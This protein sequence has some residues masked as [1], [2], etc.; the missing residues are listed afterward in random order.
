MLVL[1]PALLSEVYPNTRTSDLVSA[2]KFRLA[3]LSRTETLRYCAHLNLFVTD[4]ENPQIHLTQQ[5]QLVNMFLTEGAVK[6]VEGLA[7]TLSRQRYG[8]WLRI[9]IF[10]RGQ[11]LELIRWVSKFCPDQA[12][13]K[14]PAQ[15]NRSKKV[16][17]EAA[18]LATE[19]MIK[20]VYGHVTVDE[21]A[22]T[23]RNSMLGPVR[24][25]AL[26]TSPATDPLRA[27]GRGYRM[28]SEFLPQ[29]CHEFEQVFQEDAK[30][31]LE[32][33]YVC[34]FLFWVHYQNVDLTQAVQRH[35][36]N[37]PYLHEQIPHMAES[38][39]RYLALTAQLPDDLAVNLWI[40]E[41]IDVY[42]LNPLR[43][44]P[45][46]KLSTDTF[47]VL[48]SV[49]HTEKA[50]VG[51]LFMLSRRI[52]NLMGHFGIAFENY[53]KSILR[54][55]YPENDATHCLVD[56]ETLK[57]QTG[58]GE[59]EITDACLI[60]EDQ[61]LLFEMKSRWIRDEV[62]L[63]PNY[64]QYLDELREKYGKAAKQLA[65]N[66]NYL[67][68]KSWVIDG[69]DIDNTQRIYPILVA[70]DASLNV[71]GNAWFFASEFRNELQTDRLL[72]GSHL[73]MVKRQWEISPLIIVTVDVL[74]NLEASIHNFELT[75]LLKD[76]ISYRD[77]K[78]QGQV[79]S[80]SL[81]E[82]IQSSAYA[83]QMDHRGSVVAT[84]AEV[85]ENAMRRIIPDFEDLPGEN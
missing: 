39:Q 72:E 78:F 19:I 71:L 69:H 13:Y 7:Q 70:Y 37:L 65:R 10:H 5:R 25:S 32:E 73:I 30:L 34:L 49:F 6:R 33:F 48:D 40:D 55:M 53:A 21:G 84:S 28:F 80:L 62:V 23:L 44:K 63:Q 58:S 54:A 8:N 59:Q 17:V 52:E 85:F 47:I 45:I 77:S 24:K 27:L 14:N 38:I 1:V 79:D 35:I 56:D 15:N 22:D 42:D 67:V 18:L 43:E 4:A 51:P 74:E 64:T 41:N 26:D 20:R 76:Y 60:V 12:K 57:I 75:D 83:D 9:S 3:Q 2:I 16:F 46:L 68:E 61:L 29:E 31:S 81:N 66:I 50:M 11:L 82:Y 36:I